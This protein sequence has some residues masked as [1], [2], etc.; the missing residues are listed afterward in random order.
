MATM[1]QNL[2]GIFFVLPL[3]LLLSKSLHWYGGHNQRS[4]RPLAVGNNIKMIE[5]KKIDFDCSNIVALTSFKS[6]SSE[7]DYL[8]RRLKELIDL[9][10]KQVKLEI[11]KKKVYT[12][13]V[14][15]KHT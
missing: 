7:K 3:K 15:L 1:Y 4:E 6:T 9:E 5:K 14:I 11:K 10:E 2:P 13:C 8:L 12:N